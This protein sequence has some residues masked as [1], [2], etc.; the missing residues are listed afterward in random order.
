MMCRATFNSLSCRLPEHL[1]SMLTSETIFDYH[2]FLKIYLDDWYIVDATFDMGLK[3][4]G[5]IVNDTW[6]CKSDCRLAF[7]AEEIW[8]IEDFESSKK[9]AI[10][11]M[12]A[13]DRNRRKQ[14]LVDL[15]AWLNGFRQQEI[16]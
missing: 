5:F 11:R 14:F 4:L 12:S 15:N 1:S 16:S 9:D 3:K 10:A 8:E 2:N 6:N 13:N 7:Q